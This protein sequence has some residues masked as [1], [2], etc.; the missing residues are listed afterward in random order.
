MKRLASPVLL[1]LL[2]AS[3]PASGQGLRVQQPVIDTFGVGTTVSVPDRG[4][5][6][7]GGVGRPAEA[8]SARGFPLRRGPLARSTSAASLST[9]VFIHDFEAMDAAVL[10]AAG[11][12]GR[13]LSYSKSRYDD[14]TSYAMSRRWEAE[15]RVAERREEPASTGTATRVTRPSPAQD[16]ERILALGEAAEKRGKP[17]LATVH[18]RLAARNGS[19]EAERRLAELRQTA[20]AAGGRR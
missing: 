4:G 10:E 14:A 3:A 15:T 17:E 5:M 8:R 18:Y 2:V 16:V 12:S 9:G 19:A 11:E 6:Y 13:R 20:V 1:M 7:L